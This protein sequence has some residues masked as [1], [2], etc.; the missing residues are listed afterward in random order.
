MSV[1]GAVLGGA[2]ALGSFL[3]GRKKNKTQLKVA[4][5]QMAFQER[6]SNTAYERSMVDMK[7]AGLNP[8][9]AMKLGGA[10]TPAGAMPQISDEITPAINTG[11]QVAQTESNVTYQAAQTATEN[12]KAVL[13]QNLIPGSQALSTVAQAAADVIKSIDGLLKE[14]FGTYGQMVEDS[15]GILTDLKDKAVSVGTDATELVEY[16]MEDIGDMIS[17][18]TETIVEDAFGSGFGIVTN[19]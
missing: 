14:N 2:S 18:E 13:T 1:L 19:R 3:G 12:A 9:L 17:P 5:E 4:R 11:M 10:S 7:K 16:I 15:V 8:M 6:M